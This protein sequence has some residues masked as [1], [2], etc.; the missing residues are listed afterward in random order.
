MYLAAAYDK[1]ISWQNAF[2]NNII[3]NI[4][5]SG[6]LHYF[7]DQLQKEIYAQDA[8]KSEVV[9]L[10]LNTDFSLYQS[11][12]EIIVA[13]SNRNCFEKNGTINYTN[14]KN[15]SYNFDLIEEEIG[16][17]IL[18]G[19]KLFKVDGQRF[20]TYGF[21]GYRGG[22][23]TI[24]QD[25]VN[26]YK[27]DKLEKEERRVLYEF[28][29]KNLIDFNKFMFSIQ[30]LI[31]Y[32]KNENYQSETSIN[33]TI[34]AIPDFVKINEDCKRFFEEHPEFKLK[35]LISIYEYIELLC[36]SEIV[37]NVNE[38][39]KKKLEKEETI[40]IN[41]YFDN[42]EK[43][44]VDK[45]LLA[46]TV[47]KL[48]SR[49]LSGKRGENEIKENEHL[50]YFIQAKEEFWDKTL[51][52]NPKFDEEFEKMIEEFTVNVCQAIDFYEVLGGDKELLGDKKEFEENEN[53]NNED[54]DDN[55]NIDEEKEKKP[56]KRR[57]G[58]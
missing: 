52:E 11:F 54:N 39:Y 41:N 25:F 15:I 9:T 53:N 10:N 40:K 51:F 29:H 57:K 38:E 23:S 6:V 22:N 17:I 18:P 36:Y 20:V 16:K 48:I 45:L 31:F 21:E 35:V 28:T 4:S 42:G 26:K 33:D 14:Y 30:L 50:L 49:F 19:K 27:Q 2:L 43:K 58:Y 32:L 3:G 55:E 24:I 5:Q 47:R 8:T 44:L 37:E 13:F 12:E 56:R 1:F 7:R 46:T 34:S